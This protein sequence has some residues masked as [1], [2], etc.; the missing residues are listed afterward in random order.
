MLCK[1]GADD[2]YPLALG[3]RGQEYIQRLE[4]KCGSKLIDEQIRLKSAPS[5]DWKEVVSFW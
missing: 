5:G 1:D 2:F 4:C 3:Y